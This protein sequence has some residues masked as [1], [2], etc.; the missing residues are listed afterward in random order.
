[1]K[2]AETKV[3]LVAQATKKEEEKM[4]KYEK[5]KIS[6]NTIK[7][8]TTLD[9]FVTKKPAGKAIEEEEEASTD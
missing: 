4:S 5:P 1:M 9:A 7:K 3:A 2:Q 8:N 6:Y